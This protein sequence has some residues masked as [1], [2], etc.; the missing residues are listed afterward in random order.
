M[1]LWTAMVASMLGGPPP[2]KSAP[3]GTP[4]DPVRTCT[5]VGQV[6]EMGGSQ[7]GVCTAAESKCDAPEGCFSCMP[8]H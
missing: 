7:L 4:T 2:S 1:V 8:Q 6:C 3:E 5:E